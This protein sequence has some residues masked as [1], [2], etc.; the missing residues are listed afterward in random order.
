MPPK[1]PAKVIHVHEKLRRR[2]ADVASPGIHGDRRQRRQIDQ[3]VDLLG[4]VGGAS[5]GE[6]QSETYCYQGQKFHLSP[7][8][9]MGNILATEVT[10]SIL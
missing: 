10:I 7:C 3:P 9:V 6:P 1:R 8:T 4:R 5:R 2:R